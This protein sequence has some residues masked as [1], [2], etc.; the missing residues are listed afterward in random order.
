[1]S[2]SL[3]RTGTGSSSGLVPRIVPVIVMTVLMWVSELVDVVLNGFL[4]KFGIHPRDLESL[5]GI[6]AAPFLHVGLGHLIAN[7][8]TFVVL[9]I[10]TA[11][12]TR[13]F[14]SVTLGVVVLGGLAVWLFGAPNTV[15]LGASGLV[16]G[17]LGF[18]LVYGF[19][20][21]RAAAIAVAIGVF[22]VY[23]GIVW[24]VLPTNPYISWQGHLFGA[25][26]GCLMAFLIGRKERVALAR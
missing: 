18:L 24:G 10:A 21:R 14:W 23:G 7:T 17:Y 22:L 19:V 25:L 3:A 8:G 9:G 12:I 16:Y 5:P 15:H 6:L 11:L 4:D 13:R 20:A 2:Q 26:A 1:M